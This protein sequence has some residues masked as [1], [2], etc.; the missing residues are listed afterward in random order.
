MRPSCQTGWV[1]IWHGNGLTVRTMPSRRNLP[2]ALIIGPMKSGTSWIHDY[3]QTRPDVGLPRGV[4]ET[5]F[6]DRFYAKGIDWYAGHF[7]HH[8][9]S[10]KL[11][12]IE[13]A[14]SYFHS[15][16]APERVRSTLGNIRLVATLRDPVRRSW[17]HYLHLRRYGY[18]KKPLREATLDFPEILEASRYG[19]H[20]ARWQSCFPER[21]I[22]VLWQE[23]LSRS[24]TAYVTDL[25][26]A[27][28]LAPDESGSP[29]PEPTNAA[30]LPPS[31]RVA[32]IGNS[33][34]DFLRER[35]LYATVNLAKRLGLKKLF[36]GRPGRAKLPALK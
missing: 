21:S 6:F 9:A 10:D 15:E 16:A 5:F 7:A 3:L 30:A 13:V 4:K 25:C 29:L 34:A 31:I 22:N 2:N 32:S 17:S 33:T 19:I 36:F 1:G 12:L 24:P 20:L 18:T 35:K 23:K 14:P 27:L 28:S 8:D 26:A 11:M